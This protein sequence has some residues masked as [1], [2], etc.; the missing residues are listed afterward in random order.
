M[1]RAIGIRLSGLIVGIA[2]ALLTAAPGAAQP[3]V[4]VLT[5]E[6]SG[7][8]ATLWEARVENGELRDARPR[9]TADGTAS[10]DPVVVAGG[11]FVVWETYVGQP[12][13]V[14]FDRISGATHVLP[15][16][17]GP[18]VPDPTWPRLFVPMGN[19]IGILSAGGLESLPNSTGLV[20][21]AVSANGA[22]LYASRVVSTQPR[23]QYDV[24]AIDAIKGD[25]SGAVP[26]GVGLR[27]MA[28]AEDGGSIWVVSARPS[29]PDAL[30]LRRFE[31]PSGQERHAIELPAP[32]P[33]AT[34][35]WV[36]DGIDALR[37]R[38]FVRVGS[39]G[40]RS[41]FGGAISTYDIESGAALAHVLLF[42]K[43]DAVLDAG[44]G[45]VI[46]LS[47]GFFYHCTGAFLHTFSASTGQ[48][49]T[50]VPLGTTTCV[51][52]TAL[53]VPP[54][55]P[56]LS[57]ASVSSTRTVELSWSAA[58]ELTKMFSVEA[59]SGPGLS[60]LATLTVPSATTLTVPGV[61]PGTY[62]VRLRA[63]NDIGPS[64]PS[65]EIV[66]VVR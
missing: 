25:E 40:A 45:Q 23:A 17:R 26:V 65:N 32:V 21:L 43:S 44:A 12:T 55:P 18:V 20:P 54:R 22:L 8:R 2:C 10:D 31:W 53:A 57:P 41:S 56:L 66:V 49:L 61:P 13:L 19:A 62:F 29:A 64:V 34:E 1:Q 28:P 39:V 35:E 14:A 5:N 59:G 4:F 52:N 50:V 58:P 7:T 11:R 51:G 24:V 38:V 6:P 37:G 30:L 48:E 9:T 60:D 36:I 3:R 27:T 16:V 46:A 33:L 42:G 47:Q 63:W 15:G